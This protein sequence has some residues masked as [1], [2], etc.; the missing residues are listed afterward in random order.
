M[1]RPT[2]QASAL[3]ALCAAAIATIV[4]AAQV[5]L[6][7][8]SRRV[9]VP[10]PESICGGRFLHGLPG[11]SEPAS[12]NATP[13]VCPIVLALIVVAALLAACALVTLSRDRFA[14]LTIRLLLRRLGRLR[15]GV[16]A[17]LLAAASAIPLALA[18]APA[19]TL[20]LVS[21]GILSGTLFGAA[22]GV[23]LLLTSLARLA[24]VFGERLSLALSTVL[25]ILGC[26]PVRPLIPLV[27]VELAASDVAVLAAGR[28]LRAPPLR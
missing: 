24:S 4:L 18:V 20:T 1:L 3:C 14:T 15:V 9:A 22:F 5:G 28:A 6:A 23:A 11:A 17:V 19:P 13:G 2:S 10:F 16:T 21:V 8:C 25:R 26:D 7:L 27:W 12:G